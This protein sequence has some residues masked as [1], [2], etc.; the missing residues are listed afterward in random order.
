MV[1]KLKLLYT[2][3]EQNLIFSISKTFSYGIYNNFE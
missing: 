1:D 2:T 3:K